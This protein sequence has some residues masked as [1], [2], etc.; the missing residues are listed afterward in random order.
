MKLKI[1]KF[2]NNR[3]LLKKIFNFLPFLLIYQKVWAIPLKWSFTHSLK[4]SVND[5]DK[6]KIKLGHKILQR[7]IRQWHFSCPSCCSGSN[8]SWVVNIDIAYGTWKIVTIKIEII[9]TNKV[10]LVDFKTKS[11]LI[12]TLLGTEL[13]QG[14]PEIQCK[15][16]YQLHFKWSMLT[17]NNNNYYYYY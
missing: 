8:F 12:R 15:S 3:I 17:N 1:S 6:K 2:N 10:L 13:K 11:I 16:E 7:S 4:H 9:I 5:L 14:G